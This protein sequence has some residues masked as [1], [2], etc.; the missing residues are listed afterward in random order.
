M[1]RTSYT[2]VVERNR[3]WSGR[4][5]TEPYE[6][7]WAGE[8]IFFIR[9]LEVAG[10]LAD[11]Y[12]EVQLSPDGM[13]WCDEGTR[14]PLPAEAGEMTFARVR[15]FGGWLRL[16]GRV[17]SGEQIKVIVYLALKE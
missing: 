17:P 1:T 4:F 6:A 9:A 8:A 7:A 5:E 14:V 15:Q 3:L 16:A 12:A 13:H 2:A 11:A 10:E